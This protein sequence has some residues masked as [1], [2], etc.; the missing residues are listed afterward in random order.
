LL[1]AVSVDTSREKKTMS[2][3]RATLLAACA[4]VLM[5]STASHAAWFMEIGT[6]AGDAK[7]PQHQD[8][9]ELMSFSWGMAQSGGMSTAG[10]SPWAGESRAREFAHSGSAAGGACSGTGTGGSARI[11]K[12]NDKAS[13]LLQKAL[14][15]GSHLGDATFDETG[16]EG[17]VR[18]RYVLS[19]VTI[20]S[21]AQGSSSGGGGMRPTESIS[22]NFTKIVWTK[23]VCGGQ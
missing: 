14:L 2:N 16:R 20:T 15:R 10:R 23:P 1:S 5:L 17:S 19:N 12:L 6:I 8:W 22:L 9:V 21:L 18:A 4:G 3:P 11:V 13:P 7:D